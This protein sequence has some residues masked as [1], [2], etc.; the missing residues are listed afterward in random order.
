MTVLL[1]QY[2]DQ[3]SRLAAELAIWLGRVPNGTLR[4]R[5]IELGSAAAAAIVTLRSND[6]FDDPGT[7]EFRSGPG[8]YQTTPPWNGFVAQPGF[9]FAKPFAL[10]APSQFRPSPPPPL[11][12]AIYARAFR[13]V[14]EYG[15][16]DSTR[17][18]EDQ[19]AYAVW[20]MEF[21]E[22]SVNRLARR[23]TAERRTHLWAA[24]RLFAHLA[25]R[26]VRRLRGHVGFEVRVQPLAPVHRDSSGGHRRQPAHAARARMGAAPPDAAIS[27]VRVGP[28][29]RVRR[30]VRDPRARTWRR[31][32]VHD[33]DDDSAAG[34]ADAH[35]QEF[36][37][38]RSGVRRLTRT[39][40]LSLSV[41][42]GCG[43]RARPAGRAS[44]RR[45]YAGEAEAAAQ[46]RSKVSGMLVNT[47]GGE[48]LYLAMHFHEQRVSC[49]PT[50]FVVDIRSLS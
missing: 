3:Q 7:Y 19:T 26:T 16:I 40:R 8:E 4:E 35:L 41:C 32:L 29:H 50:I 46:R 6:G 38:R 22:G 13:E 49:C 21:A 12:S 43:P 47:R 39:S 28:F 5:G 11:T 17:R 2:P 10:D 33:G 34:D 15:A 31:C 25:C 9:R 24:A 37:R 23:L 30:L 18:T 45:P 14:K 44:R 36:P 27:R 42:D 48:V 1:S 20:W